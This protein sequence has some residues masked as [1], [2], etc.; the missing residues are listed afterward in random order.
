[1][2]RSEYKDFILFDSDA[3]KK[4]LK[5]YYDMFISYF[6][7]DDANLLHVKDILESGKEVTEVE[8]E[9]RFETYQCVYLVKHGILDTY[10]SLRKFYDTTQKYSEIIQGLLPKTRIRMCCMGISSC[11]SAIGICDVTNTA[12]GQFGFLDDIQTEVQI[13]LIERNSKWKSLCEYI[14]KCANSNYAKIKLK[15]VYLKGNLSKKF[16]REI[17]LS[18]KKAHFVIMNRFLSQFSSSRLSER[19]LEVR[20]NLLFFNVLNCISFNL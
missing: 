14:V 17:E 10:M 20:I 3:E 5:Y 9:E 1:M 11:L 7:F 4:I 12:L 8:T 19:K 13:F 18:I 2:S 15:L 6:H 16:S